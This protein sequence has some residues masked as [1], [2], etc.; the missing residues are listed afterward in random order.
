MRLVKWSAV[1][2]L[3]ALTLAGCVS[4][5]QVGTPTPATTTA[6]SKTSATPAPSERPK[7]IKLDGLDPCKALSANDQ[8]QLGTVVTQPDQ[9]DVVEG[10]KSP[11]C[12]FL[13]G[14]GASKVYSYAVH[15][16]TGKGIDYWNSSGNLDIAEKK[17]AGFPAKQVTFK[18]TSSVDCSV[19]VDVADG[20]H[21]FVQFLPIGRDTTQ[22][23][24]CQNAAKGAEL[25]L[26]TL[27]TL[28]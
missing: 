24:M 17:V 4:T 1:V 28:K 20:Q 7:D 23:V 27:Q 16:V 14:P 21:V 19:A 18:G 6:G 11:A 15:L 10:V 25:A 5:G 12:T 22:D 8:K 26:A 13:T 3:S 2:A 9:S